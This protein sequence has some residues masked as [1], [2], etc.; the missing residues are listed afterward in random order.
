MSELETRIAVIEN[1]CEKCPGIFQEIHKT[2]D[3]IDRKINNI[4]LDI[5]EIKIKQ[6]E[7]NGYSKAENK[8]NRIWLY[9]LFGSAGVI[10][11]LVEL[12][13]KLK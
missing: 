2:L 6:A 5:T 9:V 11:G 10:F 7:R 8:S 1:T 13:F 3:K 12:F 4:Y